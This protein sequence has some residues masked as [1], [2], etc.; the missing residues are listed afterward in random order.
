MVG[1]RGRGA[2]RGAGGECEVIS[3]TT[4]NEPLPHDGLFACKAEWEQ[5]QKEHEGSMLG[6]SLAP[7]PTHLVHNQ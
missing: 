7:A 4:V 6:T 2:G 1:G 3:G 5:Q